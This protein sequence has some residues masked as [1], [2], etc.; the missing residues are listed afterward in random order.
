MKCPACGAIDDRVIDSRLG[1]DSA[2]I[3]RRRE[4]LTCKKRFTT[5]ERVEEVLPFVIKK[6]GRREAYDR[7]KIV[8]GMRRACQKRPISMDQIEAVA[9]SIEQEL[10]E[11]A[12]KEIR[13]SHIGERVMQ[14][15]RHMDDV[16]YVRFASVYR[17]FRDIEEFVREI[18]ELYEL[19]EAREQQAPVDGPPN[20]ESAIQDIP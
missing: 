7:H 8:E 9:D 20:E 14:A 1:K 16:A 17:S 12:E 6:D 15:L 5:Y 10:M 13:V 18:K 11:K 3:R 19:K 4:C 2:V